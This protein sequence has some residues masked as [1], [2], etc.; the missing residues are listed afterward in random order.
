MGTVLHPEGDVLYAAQR[1]RFSPLLDGDGVASSQITS[2]TAGQ[3][4]VSVPF[5]MGTVLHLEKR[6]D[7]WHVD[8][9]FSPLLDGDGVASALVELLDECPGSFSPL[10]DGDGVASS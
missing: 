5:S 4:T 8:F 2:V 7:T 9:S 10:L 6:V 1:Q 3:I